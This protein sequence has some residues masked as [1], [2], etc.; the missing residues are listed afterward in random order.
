MAAA[1]AASAAAVVA[2]ASSQAEWRVAR[3]GGVEAHT[4]THLGEG[5]LWSVQDQCLYWVDIEKCVIHRYV[6]PA[7]TDAAAAALPAEG[8]DQEIPGGTHTQVQFGSMVGC[9]ALT[10]T[11]G[12]ILLAAASG[13]WLFDWTS[14]QSW[15]LAPFPEA[16]EGYRFNDGA[17]T[18]QGTLLVGTLF[19][20]EDKGKGLGSLWEY[21]CDSESG[22]IQP[23]RRV[24]SDL[25]IP[26]GIDWSVDAQRML[27][28]DTTRGR[29]DQF[30]F[31][32]TERSES[33]L[34]NE[35]VAFPIGEGDGHPDGLCVDAA[36]GVWVAAW[37][38]ARVTR[39]TLPSLQGGGEGEAKL[40]RTLSLPTGQTTCP[41]FGGPAL[42]DLYVTSASRGV[43]LKAQP[44][45][46]SLFVI[47][48]AGQGKPS[49][50]FKGKLRVDQAKAVKH[51]LFVG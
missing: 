31:S 21:R 18:P 38:G 2:P 35:R 32:S 48:N 4:R 44:L 51:S 50:A 22:L 14:L 12:Q 26:N 34:S 6:P 16:A 30:D 20:D 25:G 28:I 42:R 43:D 33:V 47:H 29:I 15:L 37:A 19:L 1:A 17:V 7:T 24:L 10:E 41:C 45:A 49:F 9:L 11:P 40:V 3:R 8:S 23:A 46:G 5:A 36:D 27:F 13:L 39:W